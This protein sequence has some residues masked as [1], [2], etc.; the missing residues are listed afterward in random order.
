[1]AEK[2]IEDH[3]I[4]PGREQK[5]TSWPN[6]P[7]FSDLYA[8]YEAAQEDHGYMLSKLD[9][10][11]VNM[12]GGPELNVAKGR[13]KVRPKLIRKQAEW[14]YPALEEPFLNTENMFRVKPRTFEDYK[15]A[16]Q[17]ELILNYQ[18]TTKIDKVE[19]VG[20]VVR[21]LVDEGTV[22]VKTGW[23]VEESVI[24]V[25]KEVP[26]YATP[27]QSLQMMRALVLS[28]KMSE[29][30]MQAK[31]SAGEPM[32]IGTRIK[33]VEETVLTKNNPIYEV[34][35]LRDVIIDPTCNGELKYA[36]FII[37]EYDTDMST[38][39]QQE[40]SRTVTIDE[41]TGEE[42]VE[43]NGI[44]KNLNKIQ[45]SDNT[46]SRDYYN[47]Y[48]VTGENG[49]TNFKFKDRPR[50]KLRAYEYWGYWDIDGDGEVE[51]II[52]TWVGKVLIRMEENPF[53]FDELPFSLAKYMP[54]KNEIYG[55]PDGE[56]LKENQESIGKMM[57]AAHD[58]TSTQAVG[59]EFI[60]EQFF[61]GPSQKD[62]YRTGKTVYFRHGM[63][64]R[65]AI[66]KNTVDP[67]P[68]A[69][70]DMIQYHQN[71]A[72]SMSGT[73]SFSQGIG[74]QSL[75]SVATGI[76]SAL[77]A[78]A[79]RELSILRRLSEQIF[80]DIA[81]KSIIMNQAYLEE[82]EVVRITNKEFVTVK[83]EDIQGEFD[84]IVDVS[85]PEKDNEKAEKL[86]MLM[87]TNA[88]SMDP[89]L[90]KIIYARIAKLWKE[91][92]LAEEVLNYEPEP[93]PMQ[94]QIAKLQL[95]NAMLENQK[96]KMEI[97]KMAKIIK[98]EDS[99]IEERESRTAQNLTSETEEN[100]A[101]ARLKNA[102]AK[103]LE[104][105]ADKITLDFV[106]KVDGTD[107]QEEIENKEAEWLAKSEENM[108]KLKHERELEELKAA[109]KAKENEIQQD[110]QIQQEAFKTE[111]DLSI[112][113]MKQNELASK[114]LDR[115]SKQ[116]GDKNGLL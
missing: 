68:K 90:S 115:L 91:P 12:D 92:D 26:V 18:W 13:S 43:E 77:D 70:F 5:L 103:K 98:S 67:V 89:G 72:E 73:K 110:T 52:A 97:A 16:E 57:R 42:I 83:R 101:T 78:T 106:R 84:L 23:E 58:I 25:E 19:L 21:G 64:P 50:K 29:Q 34:C 114:S 48:G 53:P 44:Y 41:R 14:K 63:D 38:L 11:E 27:E 71:D 107:R 55:E 54:R 87:Q 74:S 35:D 66:Y 24:M 36:R 30:E 102:Q 108:L 93:D 22:I 37:H 2:A 32:Q 86:N 7:K 8:D 85:T 95:E 61:A 116:R 81:R 111:K 49:E 40:F 51:P 69:V 45:V 82:E 15:A 62:N 113:E 109:V 75:G 105:E 56:L 39:K 31:M 88:A 10:F 79:K 60:D 28:G 9:E 3:G 94:E 33:E 20:D 1:M 6:E 59:Q 99:K 80:K 47:D 4:E 17:N 112:A 100:K 46:D 96:L 104:E 76:R 65:T